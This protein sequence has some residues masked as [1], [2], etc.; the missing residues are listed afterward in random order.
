MPSFC[1]KLSMEKTYQM[2]AL[3][4]EC[5]N[6]DSTASQ[7]REPSTPQPKQGARTLNQTSQPFAGRENWRLHSHKGRENAEI[8]PVTHVSG[9]TLRRTRPCG[10]SARVNVPRSEDRGPFGTPFP[11]CQ[12]HEGARR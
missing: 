5:L 4:C 2:V 3:I 10:A 7:A 9:M 1:K 6:M 8:I 12:R 11:N